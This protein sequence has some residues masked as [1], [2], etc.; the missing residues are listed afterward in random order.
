MNGPGGIQAHSNVTHCGLLIGKEF[1][2]FQLSFWARKCLMPHLH[3][4]W[5]SCAE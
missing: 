4:I 3:M 1:T 2:K 5:G